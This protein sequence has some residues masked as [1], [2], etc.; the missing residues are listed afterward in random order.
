MALELTVR[1]RREIALAAETDPIYLHQILRGI[2][3][4]KPRL[5]HT[6]VE[7]SGGEIRLWHARQSD[8][9]EVWPHLIGT[10]GA[11]DPVAPVKAQ[12]EPESVGD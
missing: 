1:R 3:D 2:K 12:S 4:A 9:W 8:W 7:A 6:L 10:E 5:A 11:P